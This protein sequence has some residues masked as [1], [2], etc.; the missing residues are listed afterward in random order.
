MRRAAPPSWQVGHGLAFRCG[1]PSPP[2]LAALA[3]GLGDCGRL[4][5][6]QVAD[7]VL[8]RLCVSSGGRDDIALVVVRL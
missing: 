2:P 8:A 1:R 7:A 4:G 3:H 6:E 5:T